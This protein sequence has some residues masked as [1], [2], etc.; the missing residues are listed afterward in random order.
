MA[1]SSPC[2]PSQGLKRKRD[3]ESEADCSLGEELR[4]L[5]ASETNQWWRLEDRET[6]LTEIMCKPDPC[7]QA[8]MSSGYLLFEAKFVF[9]EYHE[10]ADVNDETAEESNQ[11]FTE[12]D[13]ESDTEVRLPRWYYSLP[14][15]PQADDADVDHL[16]GRGSLHLIANEKGLDDLH[17]LL[18][19]L[20]DRC[21]EILRIIAPQSRRVD[22]TVV[23]AT[24]RGGWSYSRMVASLVQFMVSHMRIRV[25]TLPYAS[26]GMVGDNAVD[27]CVEPSR[28]P[29]GR[30]YVHT[31]ARYRKS[32]VLCAE[33]GPRPQKS[34]NAVTLVLELSGCPVTEV[35]F[36]S[37]HRYHLSGPL[38]TAEGAS[39]ISHFLDLI[40]G[41]LAD[42]FV[43]PD[44]GKFCGTREELARLCSA[45]NQ[46][47]K[48]QPMLMQYCRTVAQCQ[49]VLLRK[50]LPRELYDV[51]VLFTGWP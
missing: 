43:G 12:S 22:R 3:E 14:Y 34:I 5:V 32:A 49:I 46:K 30:E 20:T 44:F 29:C 26:A 28:T 25:G 24:P 10:M 36:L 6:V 41:G 13:S 51:V 27:L 4:D 37:R 15:P 11:S 21:S 9:S 7:K 45:E 47:V 48:V 8:H 42:P 17:E 2:T 19:G 23:H 31:Y 40:V 1:E 50:G 35:Y 18:S 38:M 16:R 39:R 33:A